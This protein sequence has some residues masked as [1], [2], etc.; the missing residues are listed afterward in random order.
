MS[1]SNKTKQNTLKSLGFASYNDYLNSP[2]WMRLKAKLLRGILCSVCE[3]KYANTLHHLTYARIGQESDA[4]FLRVCDTCHNLIHAELDRR[5]PTRSVE[6]K[7]TR[8]KQII[9]AVASSHTTKT[10]IRRNAKPIKSKQNGYNSH[11]VLPEE[12][13]S[14][15]AAQRD[16]QKAQAIRKKLSTIHSPNW[17][18]SGATA[19]A[20]AKAGQ[21]APLLAKAKAAASRSGLRP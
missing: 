13:K 15:A 7:A 10:P 11:S 12:T 19:S 3:H 16:N 1:T 2:H 18:R 9:K 6:Y 20:S 21:T 5:F 4:D 17:Q 14:M 8:T